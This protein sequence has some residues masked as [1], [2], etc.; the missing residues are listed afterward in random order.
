L[1]LFFVTTFEIDVFC[2]YQLIYK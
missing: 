1:P 2:E